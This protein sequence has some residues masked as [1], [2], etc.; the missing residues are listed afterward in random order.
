MAAKSTDSYGHLVFRK[1]PSR[2]DIPPLDL[3]YVK[4]GT[5]GLI[6]VTDKLRTR[7][8]ITERGI[9][10]SIRPAGGSWR[11]GRGMNI[12]VVFGGLPVDEKIR[13]NSAGEVISKLMNAQR[14]VYATIA[15]P[16]RRASKLPAR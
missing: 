12:D 13:G 2:P 6:P 8:K 15:Y 7:N 16:A 10:I 5:V 4:C 3:K 9:S 1:M 14:I 11:D